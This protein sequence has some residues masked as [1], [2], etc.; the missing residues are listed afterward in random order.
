MSAAA[1]SDRYE[2]GAQVL[3]SMGGD[4]SAIEAPLA[5]IAPELA[6]YVAEFAFG[7]LYHRDG[8]FLRSKQ[9]VTIAALVTMG[10]TER[11]LAFH[12][13]A[14]LSVGVSPR[15]I[16]DV[17]IHLLGFAGNP[18]VFNAMLTVRRVLEQEG[19]LPLTTV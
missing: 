2:R 11:Q 12:T 13:R 7:D 8:L 15:D 16:V 10:E 9:M 14:A 3:A 18:R 17:I 6:R 5:D 1:R 4:I 19:L